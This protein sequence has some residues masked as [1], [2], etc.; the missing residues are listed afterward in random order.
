MQSIPPPLPTPGKQFI[1]VVPSSG[2]NERLMIKIDGLVDILLSTHNRA[3]FEQIIPLLN[4][5][6][7][8]YANGVPNKRW[9]EAKILINNFKRVYADQKKASA[10]GHTSDQP[11]S[12]FAAEEEDA[13][14]GMTGAD[15]SPPASKK[16]KL[17]NGDEID[18]LLN[19][20]LIS[21][22]L[23]P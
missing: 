9:D 11:I 1:P 4:E 3:A 5:W 8:I 15:E 20:C 18:A 13:L 22:F 21:Q 16:P 10:R 12:S 17:F 2:R 19:A 23:K 14:S 7:K 6:R